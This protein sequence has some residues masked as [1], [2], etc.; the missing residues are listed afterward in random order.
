MHVPAAVRVRAAAV[1]AALR[2]TPFTRTSP[3]GDIITMLAALGDGCFQTPPVADIAEIATCERDVVRMMPHPERVATPLLGSA[4]WMGLFASLL[5]GAPMLQ[6][7]S[8]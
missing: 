8:A 2:D 7:G 1:A 6:G 4:P 5:H 3:T